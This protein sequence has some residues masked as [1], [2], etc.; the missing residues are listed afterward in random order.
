MAGNNWGHF[1]IVGLLSRPVALLFII[2]M[3]VAMLSTKI[4][5]LRGTYPLALPPAPP[6]IGVWAR[7]S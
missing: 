6:Q 3:L 5:M 4:P 1:L 2:E 7:A